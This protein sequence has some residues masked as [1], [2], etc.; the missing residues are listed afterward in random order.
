MEEL[1]KKEIC[2]VSGGVIP[3]LVAYYMYM[4]SVISSGYTVAKFAGN[5]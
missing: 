2:T 1:S 5:R 3:A 4:G